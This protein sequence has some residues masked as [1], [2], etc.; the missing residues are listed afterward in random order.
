MK[1]K[2]I[3]AAVFMLLYSV[4]TFSQSIPYSQGRIVISSDGNEHDEDDWA[5]TPFSLALLA[6]QG[7]QNQLKVYTF[8]D[9]IWGSNHRWPAGSNKTD[10]GALEEMRE[11]ALTGQT[12]FQFSNTNFIE[13]LSYPN[14]AY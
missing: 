8:S 2:I 4:Q 12:K 7:L 3:F 6:S 10:I 13:A 9:H 5:A 11:S 1:L 14:Q